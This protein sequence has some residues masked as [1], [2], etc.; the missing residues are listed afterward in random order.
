LKAT[1]RELRLAP[2]PD[3]LH[4]DSGLE[5]GP[6]G[7][8]PE[9]LISILNGQAKSL[10][11]TYLSKELAKQDLVRMLE[12]PILPLLV[13]TSTPQR[14]LLI[15]AERRGSLT[16]TRFDPEGDKVVTFAS[17]AELAETLAISNGMVQTYSPMVMKPLVSGKTLTGVKL[18]PIRRLWR[19]LASEKK[20]IAYIYIYAI[21]SGLLGM[22]LPL[23]VQSIVGQVSGGMILEPAV[24]LIVLVI[25]GT[26]LSG[27]L[28]IM[29]LSIVETIQQRLF[30][31]AA[32]EFSYRLPRL[33]LES[34][35]PYY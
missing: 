22:S 27:L 33:R 20:D 6:D 7:S 2:E 19:L 5:G 13:F 11:F 32:F 9:A 16:C 35:G 29:Q 4:A 23:G 18:T 30:T 24:V 17:P 12:N 25:L 34:L 1:L 3:D 10:H 14:A 8:Q 26:L 15:T 31:R 28:Q 21:V